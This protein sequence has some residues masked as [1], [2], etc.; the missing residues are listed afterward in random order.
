M[1]AKGSYTIN[2]IPLNYLYLLFHIFKF[3]VYIVLCVQS[4]A[5]GHNYIIYTGCACRNI[6]KDGV[7]FQKA[8]CQLPFAIPTPLF[9]VI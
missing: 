2:K 4:I 7:H 1:K 9:G 5:I 3:G 6:L 8:S